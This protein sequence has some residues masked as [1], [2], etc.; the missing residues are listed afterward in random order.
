MS[1]NNEPC[2]ARPTLIDLNSVELN[3]YPSMITVDKCNGS[4]NAV[5]DLSTKICVPSETNN[6][7]VKVFNKMARIYEAKKLI[8]YISCDYK[9]KFSTT[10]CNSDQKWNNDKCQCECEKYLTCKKNYSTCICENSRYL[11][12]IADDSVIECEKV[13]NHVCF[14][15]FL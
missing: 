9:W 3:Y 12:S 6:V 11:K 13:V 1:L 15:F 5:G 4:C 8:K 7:N 10:T 14:F 2:M